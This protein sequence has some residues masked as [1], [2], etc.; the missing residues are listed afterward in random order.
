MNL[1]RV[2]YAA[3]LTGIKNGRPSASS[4]PTYPT[5]PER[6]TDTVAAAHTLGVDDCQKEDETA[7]TRATNDKQA[8]K[9]TDVT[10][11]FLRSRSGSL[12]ALR[13]SDEAAGIT[14]TVA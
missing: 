14:D 6:Q 2:V 1:S 7:G 11:T 10:R 4:S 9:E 13:M 12:R 5:H 8:G 3:P